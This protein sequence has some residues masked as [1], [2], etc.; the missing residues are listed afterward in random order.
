MSVLA[1]PTALDLLRSQLATATE[2][3]DIALPLRALQLRGLRQLDL[4]VHVERLRVSNETAGGDEQ[5]EENCLLAL[6]IIDGT[7]PGLGLSWDAVQTTVSLLPRCVSS[8]D[9][10]TAVGHGLKPSD[11]LPPRGAATGDHATVGSLLSRA[12]YAAVEAYELMPSRC[13]FFRVPKSAFTTRPAALLTLPDRLILETLSSFFEAK[14]DEALPLGVIWPRLR[15]Q[16]PSHRQ[17]TD[18]VLEWRSSYVVKA[19]ISNFYE[20]VEHSLLAV[21]LARHLG[22]A[23]QRARAVESMLTAVMGLQRGLPQGP[24]ASDV[25]ASAYLLPIDSRLA[26]E[27]VQFVR[28]ADDY[29][30]P[31]DS[32]GEGRLCLHHLEGLLRDVGLALNA[33]KTQIMRLE[34]Y[35]RGLRRP[36]PAVVELKEHLT[37]LEIDGLHEMEDRDELSEMLAEAGVDEQTLWD[38]LY[39]GTTTLDEVLPDIQDQLGP[40]LANTYSAYFRRIAAT[41]ANEDRAGDFG[42]LESLARECLAFL[43][44]TDLDVRPDDLRRVQTWF[45]G[46]SPL[47]AQYLGARGGGS[48][49]VSAYLRQQL[50]NPSG[51]D[52]VDAWM[53]HATWNAPAATAQPLVEELGDLL[54]SGD[55]GPLT[56]AEALRALASFGTL[57]EQVWRGVFLAASPALRSEMFF[58]ALDELDRYPWL[59]RHL[60]EAKDPALAVVAAELAPHQA[61]DE[62]K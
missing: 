61:P 60:R 39:H 19:D 48:Q 35:E 55:A 12:T 34:T 17:A 26:D 43:T 50:S 59:S 51:V 3:E 49:W 18:Q 4:V 27:G 38:L 46:L 10:S 44:Q 14:L 15:S 24:P 58:A 6:D 37:E 13:D 11:L 53:C 41:L 28:Y 52:W 22:L 2:A 5:F 31:A 7:A 8:G 33:P 1:V 23:V 32:M 16:T 62:E 56:K 29:F 42:T 40:S 45:P 30:F 57:T 25:L 47:V 20:G 36:S 21:F 54:A 9:V